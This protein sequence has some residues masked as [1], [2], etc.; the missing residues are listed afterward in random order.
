MTALL[1]AS[2]LP[3]C[4]GNQQSGATAFEAAPTAAQSPESSRTWDA[5]L[6]TDFSGPAT[7]RF[8]GRFDFS[9]PAGPRFAWSGSAVAVHFEGTALSALLHDAGENHFTVIVDGKPRSDK[10]VPGPGERELVLA[11]N[12]EPG[13]HTVTLY[14]L[15]EPLV[16]ET[17]LRGL[18]LSPGGKMLAPPPRLKRRIELIGD[19][20]SAG[21]GNDGADR[22]CPFSPDTENH[23][24]TYG[25]IAARALAADLFTLAWS[26]KGVFSNRGDLHDPMPVVWTRTLPGRPDSSWDFAGFTPDAVV[27]NLGTNDF[28]PEVQDRSPFASSYE[29]FVVSVRQTYPEAHLFLAVG[30]M[31]SDGYPEGVPSH[32]IVQGTL[33]KLTE[34]LRQAGDNRV[35]YLEFRQ[36][37]ESDGYGCDWHPSL[38]THRR[39]A[40]ELAAA[41][42]GTLGWSAAER[43][44]VE[45]P[46]ADTERS[47]AAPQAGAVPQADAS[48]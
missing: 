15:T 33:T 1:M 4:A 7:P 30:P 41:L 21:Y 11:K 40:G 9:D 19:S 3:A 25:A 37:S 28:A 36:Q 43:P 31:L 20:I 32:T 12:L 13:E 42:S 29:R 27:V 5:P 44:L 18:R 24:A 35:H 17:Q 46:R 45:P 6:I 16:G 34:K 14:R 2:L 22:N 47:N 38:K 8:D 39:M 26:G 23:Y 10:L 48:P